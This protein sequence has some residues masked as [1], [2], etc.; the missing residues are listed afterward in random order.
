M[1]K[2]KIAYAYLGFYR[3]AGGEYAP[4][5]LAEELDRDR[6]D[7]EIVTVV[8]TTSSLG[9]AAERTGCPIHALGTRIPRLVEPIAMIR[10]IA[11]FYRTFRRLK[12]DVV[13]TQ[14]GFCNQWARLAASLAGVPVIIGTI[15][16]DEPARKWYWRPLL[17][18]LERWLAPRTAAYACIGA[19]LMRDQLPPKEWGRVVMIPQAFDLKRFLAGRTELPAI[20]RQADPDRPV[21]GI[22]GRLEEEK[23]HAVAI[24]AMRRIVDA[25]PAARL[26]I[27][28]AGSLEAALRAQVARLD[29][30][31][32]V[33][34]M[35]HS[36]EVCAVMSGLDLL[37]V[38]SRNEGFGVVVLESIAAGV[39]ML[40]S[41]AG[42]FPE[43]LE[44]GK[45]GALV[46][47]FGPAAWADAVLATIADRGP[48][49]A[50]LE[51][52]RAELLRRYTKQETVRQHARLY[53]R[54]AGPAAPA[55]GSA[56]EPAIPEGRRR[57]A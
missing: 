10:M 18:A 41:R 43:L 54:L 20:R 45:Y 32:N 19:H 31:D 22:V 35:G 8:P 28:G 9:A 34:F 56:A 17:G 29:L 44:E 11:A 26:K 12:P 23:G 24:E 30:S 13:Q 53:E 25:I 15:N 49:V 14:S 46:A 27:V 16:F 36:T 38:P 42:A 1:N 55:P 2:I 6:F 5:A 50:K 52:A 51:K 48:A 21:L 7:F 40:G 4:L 39:P 3:D 47:P 57:P 33:D 37:L